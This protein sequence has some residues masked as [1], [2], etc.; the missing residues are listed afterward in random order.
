M[1]RSVSRP[2]NEREGGTRPEPAQELINAWFDAVLAGEADEPHPLYGDRVKVKF[3]DG[4]MTLSGEL[5][6][7]RDRDE[8]VGQARQRISNGLRAV[9]ASNLRV[10]ERPE[11]R[12][13]LEQT[14]IAA[15]DEPDVVDLVRNFVAQRSSRKPMVQQIVQAGEVDRLRQLLPEAFVQEAQKALEKHKALLILRVDETDA[16]DVRR[17]LE[18][19]TRSTWTIAVPPEVSA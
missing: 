11:R 2:Q 4:L 15:F 14:L 17:L 1:R 8:L 16:F 13:V 19:D 6:S 18:E 7:K 10:A 5:D 3:A 9:D 12:G